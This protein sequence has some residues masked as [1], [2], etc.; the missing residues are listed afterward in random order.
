MLK[1]EKPCSWNLSKAIC[2][3]IYFLI[4]FIGKKKYIKNLQNRHDLCSWDVHM[5][6]L[7]LESMIRL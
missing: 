1:W 4:L 2:N 3:S 6:F 7:E 5:Q